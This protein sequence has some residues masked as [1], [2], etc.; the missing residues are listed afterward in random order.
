MDGCRKGGNT[1]AQKAW[2]AAAVLTGIV[3]GQA[4][5][6]EE[7]S[8]VVRSGDSLLVVDDSQQG[9]YFRVPLSKDAR[10]LI[11]LNA[12]KP[13]RVR[14]R[15]AALAVDL[16]SIDVLADGRVALL[17][18]R[19][20]SLVS[21]GGVIVE[22]DSGL[23]EVGKR[24]LEGVSA[25]PIGDGASRVAVVWEGGY[26]DQ[27]SLPEMLKSR[28]GGWALSPLVLIHDIPRAAKIG[29]LPRASTLRSFQ[30][31]VPSPA[32]R[33]RRPQRFRAP[34]LTWIRLKGDEWGLLVLLSAQNSG[35]APVSYG[36]IWLQRFDL[37]GQP[38][39]KH[40]DLRPMLPASVRSA[41]WE[42][43]A[44]WEEGRSLVMVHEADAEHRAHGFIIDLAAWP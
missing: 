40:L 41:N 5:R 13:E 1:P 2:L 3:C 31:D 10:G 36:P 16:E 44:W 30:L 23:A 15:Q 33:E 39:G 42:G 7:A 4:P 20:R 27:P 19:L 6:I 12:R 21:D 11:D 35:S 14:L 28:S 17:S 24:G 18:E 25:R 37:N 32:G 9:L 8:G 29:R 38:V 34:D 22:Y 26:P 43:L